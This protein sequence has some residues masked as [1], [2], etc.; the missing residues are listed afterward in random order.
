[1][2]IQA[3]LQEPLAIHPLGHFSIPRN[4]RQ[5]MHIFFAEKFAVKRKITIFA[6][7]FGKKA[8]VKIGAVVQ[9]G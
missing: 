2:G 6:I 7:A 1:M 8:I 5:K 4:K 9:F 3:P